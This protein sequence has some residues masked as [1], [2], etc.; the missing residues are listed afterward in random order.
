[1][2]IA[3]VFLLLSTCVFARLGETKDQLVARF[4][5]PVNQGISQITSQSRTMV[6]GPEL[7]F[8]QKDWSITC[9]L[10]DGRCARISYR[11]QG[12]WTE[13]QIQVVLAV[14]KQGGKWT[15]QSGKTVR[16]WKRDDG[17]LAGWSEADGI[18]ITT[19]AYLHAKAILEA[20]AKAEASVIP[21]I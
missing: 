21:N 2:K 14:N 15:E 17:A 9:D 13:E 16:T 20:K 19:P 8:V 4:D 11:K 7:V 10:V 5:N 6:V 3:V 12:D 18:S 1:M